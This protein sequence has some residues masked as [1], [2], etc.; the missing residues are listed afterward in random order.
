MQPT[1]QS[2]TRLK[3]LAWLLGLLLALSLVLGGFYIARLS[4]EVRAGAAALEA[5][6]RELTD[7]RRTAEA[8]TNAQRAASAKAQAA[9][10]GRAELEAKLSAAEAARAEAEAKLKLATEKQPASAQE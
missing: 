6:R 3:R 8:A 2:Q 7:V 4:N 10:A 9:E 1:I 5:A